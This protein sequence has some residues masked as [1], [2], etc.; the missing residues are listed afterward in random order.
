MGTQWQP[1]LR[2]DTA[3]SCTSLCVP[4]TMSHKPDMAEVEKFNESKLKKI[5]MQ[6]KN[7]PQKKQQKKQA[8]KS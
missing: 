7:Y 4:V 5:E 8:G 1:L 3:C 2:Q 6:E